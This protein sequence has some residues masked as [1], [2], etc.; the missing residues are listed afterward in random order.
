MYKSCLM[1]HQIALSLPIRKFLIIPP[2]FFID[3]ADK[4][5]SVSRKPRRVE[6]AVEQRE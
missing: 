3:P 6:R 1:V 5:F 4:H 2:R